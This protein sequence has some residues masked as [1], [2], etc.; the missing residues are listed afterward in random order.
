[1]CGIS[2]FI[3][4]ERKLNSK[5]LKKYS[6]DMSKVLFNRGPNAEGYWLCKKNNLALSHRR[7]S[8]IDLNERSTQPMQSRNKRFVMIFNGEIYN[9][10][11]LKNQ[12]KAKKIHFNTSSDTEVLLEAISFWG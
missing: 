12:L 2:G 5:E 7:L 9:F 11:L 3:K 1:M 10:K 6:L 4:F 8:I